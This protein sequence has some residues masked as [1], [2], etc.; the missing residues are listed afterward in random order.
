MMMIL[1]VTKESGVQQKTIT[2]TI[3][4]QL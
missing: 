2:T 3:F 4:P 1:I